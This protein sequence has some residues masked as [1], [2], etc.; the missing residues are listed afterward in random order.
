[1]TVHVDEAGGRVVARIDGAEDGEIEDSVRVAFAMF[2]SRG[3]RD[4]VL[5]VAPERR[6]PSS[7]VDIVTGE[8]E[9][10]RAIGALWLV[11]PAPSVGFFA[12]AIGLRVQSVTVHGVASLDLVDT[13][14]SGAARVSQY[15]PAARISSAAPRPSVFPSELRGPLVM[16]ALRHEEPLPEGVSRAFVAFR[17][18]DARAC[19]ILFDDAS[20]PNA[21]LADTLV[22]ELEASPTV[23]ALALVHTSPALG[24]LASA[25]GLRAPH[26]RVRAFGDPDAA[27]RAFEPARG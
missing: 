16:A 3:A 1:M 5:A 13:D 23:R 11:H 25:V 21:T 12:S 8:L 2:R 4:A 18:R 7:L 22:A 19:A 10:S 15:P 6:L 26:V 17:Q 9:S 20:H 14:E 27:Q 24:F